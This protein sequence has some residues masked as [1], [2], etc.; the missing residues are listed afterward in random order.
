MRDHVI[1]LHGIWMR[2]FTLAPFA[3][4]L[5]AAGFASI[6]TLDYA[7]LS[8]TLEV[9]VERLAARVRARDEDTVHIVGHS[10]GGML[11]VEFALRNAQVSSGRI[12]CLGSPLRGSAAARGVNRVPVARMIMGHSADILSRGFEQ[13]DGRRELGVIAGR[14]PLGLGRFVGALDGPHDGTVSVA[15]TMLPGI[16]DHCIVAATHSGLVFSDEVAQRVATFL[17][18]GRFPPVGVEA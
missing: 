7:S 9:A 12:V 2:G 5:R 4:R 3:R 1:L 13:W 6:E 16:T 17:R 14:T 15:E 10:L 18:S 11:A 8:G